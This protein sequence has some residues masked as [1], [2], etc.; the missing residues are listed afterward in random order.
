[1]TKSH[2]NHGKIVH[3]PCSS[4]ISSRGNLMETP[5]SFSY[6]LRLE[7]VLRCLSLSPY[8]LR[9]GPCPDIRP[10]MLASTI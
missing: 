1:M 7:V 10:Y 6:Q 2:G 4:C 3:R 5:L 9:P 8:I